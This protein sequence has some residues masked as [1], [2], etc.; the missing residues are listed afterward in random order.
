[1]A[2]RL[3]VTRNAYLHIDRIIEFNDLRNKS[4]V[5]SRKI[6]KLL[7]KEFDLLKRLPFM[8]I[9]TGQKGIYRLVWNDFYIFY[10]ITGDLI[11]IQAVHHQKEDINS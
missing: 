2:K 3:A 6:V 9:D 5:Y 10:T 4:S 1:M 11:E 8:G 7:F